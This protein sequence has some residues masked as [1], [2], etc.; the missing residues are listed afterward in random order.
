MSRGIVIKRG[1]RNKVSN[2]SIDIDGKDSIAI[3]MEETFD[4]EIKDIKISIKDSTEQFEEMRT[5]ILNIQDNSINC[6]TGNNYK[7]DVLS[8]ISIL[9]NEEQA[10]V[11]SV[12]GLMGLLSSWITIQSALTPIIAPYIVSLTT[13]L[14]AA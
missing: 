2:A 1:G 11:T 14:G 10:S 12:I 6:K 8:K 5:A 7:S 13:F 3:E 4:N 9:I